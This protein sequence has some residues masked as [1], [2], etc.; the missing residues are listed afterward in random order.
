MRSRVRIFI[1]FAGIQIGGLHSQIDPKASIVGKW[2]RID[3]KWIDKD[4]GV[5]VKQF[6]EAET[7]YRGT[8]Y[9]TKDGI[10]RNSK[11]PSF[12]QHSYMIND[13]ILSYKIPLDD[14]EDN[15]IIIKKLTNKELI[16]IWDL[17]KVYRRET[18][19]KCK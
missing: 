17:K 14:T 11:E 1:L 8:Y 3:M 7:K 5:T 2:M 15:K 9:F 12:D 16:L 4:S 19:L 13:T 10:M 6:D 18:Y